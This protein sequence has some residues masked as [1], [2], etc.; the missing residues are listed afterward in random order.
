MCLSYD[1]VASSASFSLKRPQNCRLNGLQF[2]GKS[3]LSQ[4]P[5][6]TSSASCVSFLFLPFL[7]VG[8]FLLVPGDHVGVENGS[9]FSLKQPQNCRLRL[10]TYPNGLQFAG[11][12]ARSQCPRRRPCPRPRGVVG[13]VSPR[14]GLKI[15]GSSTASNLSGS[16][17]VASVL[18]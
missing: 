6:L 11:K 4:C 9:V 16:R 15:V 2:V 13:F 5:R 14:N 10:R 17:P 12:S 1:H 7:G 18:D 3:A 8:S